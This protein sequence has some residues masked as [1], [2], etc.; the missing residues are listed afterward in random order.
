MMRSVWLLA[1]CC[2]SAITA[3][4]GKPNL[5]FMM[6]DQQR[7]DTLSAVTPSFATPNLDKIAAEGVRHILPTAI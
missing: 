1:L 2:P 4:T 7:H 3:A 6:T 5:L